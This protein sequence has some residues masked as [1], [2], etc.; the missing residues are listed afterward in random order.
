MTTN[1][2]QDKGIL[3]VLHN[4][5]RKNTNYCKTCSKIEGVN[6]VIAGTMNMVVKAN[7]TTVHV[8]NHINMLYKHEKD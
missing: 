1:Y 7:E 2:I 4:Y 8:I 3:I 5:F 6:T